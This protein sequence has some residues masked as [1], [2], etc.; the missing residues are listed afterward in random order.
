MFAG[1]S[2]DFLF[3]F[4]QFGSK[5]DLTTYSTRGSHPDQVGPYQADRRLY[6]R[7]TLESLSH[8]KQR[9]GAGVSVKHIREAPL[10]DVIGG[11]ICTEG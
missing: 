8:V 10:A 5:I 2:L 7:Q 1:R 11:F 6:T 9:A 4:F 3:V